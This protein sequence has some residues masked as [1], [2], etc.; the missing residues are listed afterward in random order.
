[1]RDL[2]TLFTVGVTTGLT[3]GQL[4][5][6]FTARSDAAAERAFATLIERHGPM[7]LRACRGILRD[8]HDAQDAFQATFLTLVR[9]GSSLW[10][11]DSLGPGSTGS[12]AA[13]PSEPCSPR[14]DEKRPSGRRPRRPG[15]PPSWRM[16]TRSWAC[17]TRKSIAYPVASE[18]R[19]CSVTWRVAPTRRRR[20][21]WDVRSGRSRAAWL[22]A[23]N[24]CGAS[25]RG[26]VSRRRRHSRRLCYRPRCLRCLAEN[27]P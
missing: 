21:T 4:L 27:G 6:R 3:D 26:G 9:S 19:S 25:S 5:E 14:S 18:S 2:R 17:S 20:D 1:M 22:V 13:S 23:V 8:D 24:D 7:V 16:R 10:V 11:R 12:P 15:V